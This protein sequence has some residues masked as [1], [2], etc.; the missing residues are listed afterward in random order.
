MNRRTLFAAAVVAAWAT[1][2]GAGVPD[3]WW[4]M[5]LP[6]PMLSDV[7]RDVQTRLVSLGCFVGRAD[8]KI[9]PDTEAAIRAWQRANG[10]PETGVVSEPLMV[11]LLT[12]NP[13]DLA[14]CTE[15]A[16]R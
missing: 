6:E 8:G 5:Q 9:G 13:W 2:G 16:G 1:E 7:A 15:T 3:E 4:S 11:T 12:T 10:V 14:S